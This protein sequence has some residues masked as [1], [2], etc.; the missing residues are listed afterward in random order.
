MARADQPVNNPSPCLPRPLHHTPVR[1]P[2][3]AMA[4]RDD[5][6]GEDDGVD[7]TSDALHHSTE[8]CWQ[9]FHGN[10]GGGGIQDYDSPLASSLLGPLQDVFPKPASAPTAAQLARFQRRDWLA[11]A[12]G[13]GCQCHAIAAWIILA[14]DPSTPAH[15]LGPMHACRHGLAGPQRDGNASQEQR[16]GSHARLERLPAYDIGLVISC[17]EARCVVLLLVEKLGMRHADI[18]S[19][20]RGALPP[21]LDAAESVP[22]TSTRYQHVRSEYGRPTPSGRSELECFRWACL[23]RCG[24]A[25]SSS[26]GA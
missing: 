16:K 13:L 14:S 19:T 12:Q 2:H 4:G 20:W 8:E 18:R 5:A 1:S 15:A 9:Q 6:D 7:G 23:R 21:M 25:L 17:E 3:P 10:E 22:G 24:A 26:A 11:A